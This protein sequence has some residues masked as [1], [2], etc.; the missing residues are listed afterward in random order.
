MFTDIEHLDDEQ[1][2]DI[3]LLA[4]L[5]ITRGTSDTTFSPDEPVTR[6][7]MASFLARLARHLDPS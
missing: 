6:A 7:Q 3:A 5:A 2:A 4:R 1:Q